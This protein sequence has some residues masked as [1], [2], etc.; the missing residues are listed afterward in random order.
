MQAPIITPINFAADN[1]CIEKSGIRVKQIIVDRSGLYL[2]GPNH[3]LHR[4]CFIFFR[5]IIIHQETVELLIIEQLKLFF[6]K[7][8]KIIQHIIRI[9]SC[10][11][12]RSMTLVIEHGI[13]NIW[14]R[15][16]NSKSDSSNSIT[17]GKTAC[18]SGNKIPGFSSIRAFVNT[19]G[20]SP[21]FKIPGTAGTV[22]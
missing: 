10:S 9:I 2:V 13:N 6:G 14:I 20:L 18:I 1:R 3:F 15:C 21:F 19:G 17:A 5:E 7:A 11:G 4:N 12:V 8:F 16:K 22:P